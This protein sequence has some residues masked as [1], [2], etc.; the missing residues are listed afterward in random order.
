MMNASKNDKISDVCFVNN[1]MFQFYFE[2]TEAESYLKEIAH[3]I[4]TDIPSDEASAE[5]MLTK[6][7]TVQ[8]LTK[9]ERELERDK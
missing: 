3:L 8:V 9:I 7:K 6:H 1:S 2:C 4:T 5:T